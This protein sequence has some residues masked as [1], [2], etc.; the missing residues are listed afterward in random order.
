MVLPFPPA[1]TLQLTVVPKVSALRYDRTQIAAEQKNFV[2]RKI[3]LIKQHSKKWKVLGISV[4]TN[5]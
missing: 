1:I 5:F 2:L 3:V 4:K